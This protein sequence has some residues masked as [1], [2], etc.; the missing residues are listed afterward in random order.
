MRV[1]PDQA[2]RAQGHAFDERRTNFDRVFANSYEDRALACFDTSLHC[3]QSRDGI[4]RRNDDC[5][6]I[7]T[8]TMTFPADVFKA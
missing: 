7:S 4:T 5:E 1:Q 8:W 2:S 6:M 3:L